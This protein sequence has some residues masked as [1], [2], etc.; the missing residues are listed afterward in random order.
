[1]SQSIHNIT[2]KITW[3]IVD[4]VYKK[5]HKIII[6]DSLGAIV[7]TTILWNAINHRTLLIWLIPELIINGLGRHILA[8]F[9]FLYR[10]R[11]QIKNVYMWHYLYIGSLFISGLFWG[12]G[13]CLYMFTPDPVYRLVVMLFMTGIIGAAIPSYIPS[14]R[15]NLAFVIPVAIAM[16]LISLSFNGFFSIV[17][18][19]TVLIYIISSVVSTFMACDTMINAF[20]LSLANI[21]L[22]ELVQEQ[23][24]HDALTGLFNRRYLMDIL[25]RELL[26]IIRDKKTLCVGMLDLD[27]F[28]RI[29][30][31]YGHKAGDEILKYTGVLLTSH[32][33]GND[34]CCRFGGDEFFVVMID[35]NL[36][37][38]IQR[39]EQI[40]REIENAH[41]LFQGFSLP[42]ITVSIGIAEA[43]THALIAEK[44]IQLA[45]EALYAA[46][47]SGKNKLMIAN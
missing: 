2:E 1:M 31:T 34:I 29:N 32:F 19:I 17:L 13:G 16:V 5:F 44:I 38:A 47:A 35:S 15:S 28:K 20:R 41:I 37:D 6:A 24:I 18:T 4:H 42:N 46:K 45:D 12:I 21:K 40:R 33:R 10:K 11:G 26:R 22:R 14:K 9:F 43:P 30:D 25:P 27:C 23:A 3:E 36:K 7:F 39:F 8:F